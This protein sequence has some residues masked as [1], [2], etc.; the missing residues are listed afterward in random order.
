MSQSSNNQNPEYFNSTLSP[1]L[2]IVHSN[3][4]FP[5]ISYYH[6]TERLDSDMEEPNSE[7]EL[8]SS[9]RRDGNILNRMNIDEEEEED[10]DNEVDQGNEED[11]EEEEDLELEEDGIEEEEEEDDGDRQTFDLQKEADACRIY[12]AEHP[13]NKQ[14]IE[15]GREITEHEAIW[16]V[17]TFRP[18]W[19][20]EKMRDNNP[21]T[22][23]QSDSPNPKSPHTVDIYFHQATVIKQVSIFTDVSQDESYTPKLISIRGGTNFRDLHEIMELECEDNVGWKN[24][25]FSSISDEPIR[26]FQ[27][28]I[29]VLSTHFNGRDTH[30]RQIKVY[31]VPLPY[32]Q[33]IIDSDGEISI[34][35]SIQKK[36]LR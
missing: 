3:L 13:D 15:G 19:G 2:G 16:T 34:Q 1:N 33:E 35:T 8:A 7:L 9:R 11:E 24:A 32:T 29:A 27:L 17:S 30:I 10:H 18:D 5:S 6:P 4:D 28:Q 21:L 25:D 31:S 22:Y 36:G 20:V 23:W 26:V 12:D 14:K